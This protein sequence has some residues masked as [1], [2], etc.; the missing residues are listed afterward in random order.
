LSIVSASFVRSAAF[1]PFVAARN[2][3]YEASTAWRGRIGITGSTLVRNVG[4]TDASTKSTVRASTTRTALRLFDTVKTIQS[5]W[6]S[7]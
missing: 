7:W 4:S 6:P 5:L 2:A 3:A 1:T